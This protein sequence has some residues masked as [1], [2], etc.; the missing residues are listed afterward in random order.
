MTRPTHPIS[1][2]LT[3]DLSDEFLAPPPVGWVE[4]GT[5]VYDR[6]TVKAGLVTLT[7][8][9]SGEIDLHA[10]F[11]P[12]DGIR[13]STNRVYSPQYSNMASLRAVG[14]DIAISAAGLMPDDPLDV[15]AFG[16]TSAAMALGSDKVAADIRKHKPNVIVTDPIA[17]VLTGLR[18][19]GAKRVAVITP[20]IGEVNIGIADYLEKLGLDLTAKGFFRIY[21]DNQRNRLSL[22]SYLEAVNKITKAAPCDAVFIS[23]TALATAPYVARIEAEAG[24]PV[25]TSNQALAWNIMRLGGH[26]GTTDRF[27]TLFGL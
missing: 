24:V 13:L 7:N 1:D 3:E 17:S 5:Q 18:A 21:D 23:C 22:E 12:F 26:Q 25:V 9:P 2:E 27:G 16:C 8:D 10:Y 11:A 6:A 19:L 15:L 4:L 20:Y 14:E